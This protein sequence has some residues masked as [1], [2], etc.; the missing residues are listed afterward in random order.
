MNR[1]KISKQTRT[2]ILQPVNY[3][4]IL[5]EQSFSANINLLIDSV[6]EQDAGVLLNDIA[7]TRSLHAAI[8]TKQ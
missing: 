4:K 1:I 8:K 5:S 7:H 3:W 6:Q 2:T